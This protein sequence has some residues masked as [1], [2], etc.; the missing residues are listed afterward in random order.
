MMPKLLVIYN[1]CE[2]RRNNLMWYIDCL[3]NLLRQD[4]PDFK[5]AISGCRMTEASKAGLKRRFGKNLIYSFID[6]D[7]TISVTFNHTVNTIVKQLGEFDGYVYIDSGMN[8]QNQTHAL[9]EIGVRAQTGEYGMLTV[10][11]TTDTGYEGW[12][13]KTETY[14]FTGEDFPVPLGKC[15]SLHF[16]YFN[17]K[18]LNYY[19]KL[20]PD[21][22]KAH[23]IESVFSFMNA[24]LKL[25]WV[26]IK[27]LAISHIKGADGPCLGF[28]QIGP[29]GKT[30][31]NLLGGIDVHKVLVNDTARKLGMG[32]EEMAHVMDHDPAMYDTNGFAI[33]DE[34]K[35]FIRD[36]LFVKKN[37]V[38]YDTIKHQLII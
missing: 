35:N 28:E 32:Y 27:D 26:F 3:N 37:I 23:C 15:C 19:G 25:K 21:I 20:L 6:E 16:Q 9:K 1:T 38:D 13:G 2:I 31:N 18:L 5:V 4:Y 8:T 10:Q 30:W 33:H 29:F 12:F 14:T 36:N 34:L 11:S 17:P 24:A 7:Q 22:F